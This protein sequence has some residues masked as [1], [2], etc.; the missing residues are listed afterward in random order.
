MESDI[1][2]PTTLTF[3]R[4]LFDR[5]AVGVAFIDRDLHYVMVNAA[6]AK[7]H[8]VEASAL[9]GRALADVAPR[10]TTA[11]LPYFTKVLDEGTSFIGVQHSGQFAFR[12]DRAVR[13]WLEDYYPI[14]N[15]GGEVGGLMVF[16]T[17][18]TDLALARRALDEREQQLMLAIAAAGLGVWDWTPATDVLRW[19]GE[20]EGMFGLEH[21][22]APTSFGGYVELLH[23]EDRDRVVETVQ[24]NLEPGSTHFIEHRVIHPDGSVHWIEGRGAAL[25]G[26]GDQLTGMTGV[27]LDITARKEAEEE[28]RRLYEA[29][30]REIEARQRA[31]EERDHV[32]RVLQQSLLPPHLP[33]IPGVVLAARYL[34]LSETVGGDFYDVFPLRGRGW[35]LMLGDVCGK[36]PDAASVTAM[37]RYTVR[38]AAMSETRP[39]RILRYLNEALLRDRAAGQPMQFCTVAFARVRP[40]PG[41]LRMQVALAGHPP[42]LVLRADGTI[43]QLGPTGQLLGVLSEPKLRDAA[44]DLLAG[45]TC[46][47]YTD[48]AT[49]ITVNGEEFG[50]ERLVELVRG[51]QGLGPE[52]IATA[53]VEAVQAFQGDRLRDD[54]AL[55]VFSVTG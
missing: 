52:S 26:E 16:I 43:E 17:E 24:R 22:T 6:L 23:P 42:L 31:L 30:K 33:E 38:T 51:C 27:S 48:G 40:E 14:R 8:G 11:L 55:L 37:A 19:S 15:E 21:G 4:A 29:A 34:P 35:A 20:L 36:G 46:V 5:T 9:D 39:S 41:R 50:H 12:P 25:R 18:I 44:L 3:L 32:A 54:L 10:L 28:L 45:D 49:D 2:P 7:M 53:I 13:R 1:A 47:L